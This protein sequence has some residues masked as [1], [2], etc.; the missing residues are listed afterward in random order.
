MKS[1]A[2][3]VMAFIAIILLLPV[4]IAVAILIRIVDRTSPFFKQERV[5]LNKQSFTIF[6]FKTMLNNEVTALGR[7]L[8]R[9]GIDE[10]PQL[11]NILMGQMSFVGPRP[12]TRAD[13]ERLGWQDKFYDRRWNVKPGIV[14]LAQ[15]SPVCHKRMSWYLDQCYIQKQNLML[16][17]RI[18]TMS[19][20]IPI[21]GKEQIKKWLHNR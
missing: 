6:K 9:T 1:V 3:S 7:V 10:L 2:D 4:L 14:G 19:A 20:M 15:L 12:L 11:L 16:D 8:R 17:L 5:G 13:I 21:I 18:M